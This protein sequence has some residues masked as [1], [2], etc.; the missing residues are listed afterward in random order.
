M[1]GT[2]L[3]ILRHAAAVLVLPGTATILVPLWIWRRFGVPIRPPSAAFDWIAVAAGGI[4]FLAGLILFIATVTLF[5]TQGRGT[6]APW[7]PPK[8]LVV[9]GAYRFVRNPMISGVILILAGESVALRSGALGVWTAAVAA[10]NAIYIPLF[11]EWQL[12]R[13]FADEYRRYRRNVP[14]LIPR[15]HPWRG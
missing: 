1:L 12:E 3:R 8:H 14:R 6:L 15:L 13:R 4:L 9:R 2:V 7:D 5:A 10:L 11:E